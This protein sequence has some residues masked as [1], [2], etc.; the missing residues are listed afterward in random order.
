MIAPQMMMRMMSSDFN[1]PKPA[2]APIV[3]A[4]MCH[5]R[6]PASAA[7]CNAREWRVAFSGHKFYAKNIAFYGNIS[8]VL[9]LCQFLCENAVTR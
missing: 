5:R 3:T 8:Q 7:R 6:A 9:V 4:G 2:D 1:T